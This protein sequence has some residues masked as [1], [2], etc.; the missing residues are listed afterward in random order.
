MAANPLPGHLSPV[1]ALGEELVR[2][3]HKVTLCTTP[4]EGTDIAKK[5]ADSTGMYYISAGKGYLTYA[6][7][8]VAFA[9]AGT[10]N[11]SL[12]DRWKVFNLH[13]R[14]SIIMGNFL[15]NQNLTKYDVII[16]T[17]RLAPV[18]ACLSQRW[19]IPGIILGTTHQFQT[20][21]LPQWPFPPFYMKKQGSLRISD[22][23][24]FRE[25][26]HAVVFNMFVVTLARL[27]TSHYEFVCS[28]STIGYSYMNDYLGTRAPHII[29]TAIGF[30]YPRT[31]SSLTHYVGP[32]LGKKH[33]ALPTE[34]E[35]WL[36]SKGDG[37]VILISMGSVAHLMPEQAKVIVEAIHSTDYSAIWSLRDRNRY[38]LEGLDVDNERFHF[39]KWMPQ[40]AV[41]NHSA[42]A[43]AILHGGMNGVHE[44]ISYGVPVI[45]IPF[46]SDQG[47]VAARL[48]HAGAGIQILRQH[49]TVNTLSAA[50]QDV[51]N[52]I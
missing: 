4:M 23:M 7:Y 47:D 34:I 51:Q 28:D 5:I 1:S 21:H 50:I 40:V 11:G 37:S 48:H 45:A 27:F 20:Q 44:A 3:G 43:M 49:L 29:P 13:P 39:C 22:D 19:N 30:E 2:R 33:Q 31:I 10:G 36:N 35:K 42:T 41:L 52:G 12:S 17:E 32:L 15:D 24:T 25:R 14:T 18:T 6:E 16:A 38:I 46:W 26:L 8:E 9:A